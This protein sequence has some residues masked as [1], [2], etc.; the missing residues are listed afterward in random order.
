M[1]RQWRPGAAGQCFRKSTVSLRLKTIA[2][3]DFSTDKTAP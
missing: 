2:T 3:S 1:P